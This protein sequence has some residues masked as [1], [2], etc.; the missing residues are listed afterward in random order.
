MGT[1]SGVFEVDITRNTLIRVTFCKN[2]FT[3]TFPTTVFVH[4]CSCGTKILLKLKLCTFNT[5]LFFPTGVA[6]SCCPFLLTC[7][8]LAYKLSFLRA[9]YG[10][11]VLSVKPRRA[12]AHQLGLT[13]TFGPVNSL[14]NV[15][16]T[17]GF[18]RGHLGPVKASR[19][20]LLPSYRFRTVHSSSLSALVTP[21]LAV[22]LIALTIVVIV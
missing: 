13:R 12:T 18:V 19:Q 2:C 6:N 11:C 20:T 15:C 4:G 5:F 3:V 8:V 10:P 16:I 21:C 22:K 1:F 17:V 7:F 14:L 9:D